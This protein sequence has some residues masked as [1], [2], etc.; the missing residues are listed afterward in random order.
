LQ[1]NGFPHNSAFI[2]INPNDFRLKVLRL[3]IPVV[4]VIDLKCGCFKILLSKVA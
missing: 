4:Q 2:R 3:R 1:G